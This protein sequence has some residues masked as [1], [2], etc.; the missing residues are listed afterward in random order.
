MEI[1]A[2]KKRAVIANKASLEAEQEKDAAKKELEIL[3]SRLGQKRARLPDAA[4]EEDD[5]G[6]ESVSDWEI[7]DHREE[8][9]RVQ[10]RRAIEL[11]SRENVKELRRGEV[12][13]LAHPRIGLLKW[14]FV[15]GSWEQ[16]HSSQNDCVSLQKAQSCIASHGE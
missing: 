13:Y 15:L 7:A 11:G 8:A 6:E 2:A 10:N 3:K 9:T 5:D 12:D 14:G 1:E 4:E 16:R